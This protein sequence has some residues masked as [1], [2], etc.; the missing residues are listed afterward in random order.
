MNDKIKQ[1]KQLA[2]ETVDNID[3]DNMP[4]EQYRHEID[5]KFAE[6]IILECLANVWYTR[7][8]TINGNISESIKDRIKQHFGIK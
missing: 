1:L 2:I 5:K 7:E 8:D 6:L 3:I 4:I